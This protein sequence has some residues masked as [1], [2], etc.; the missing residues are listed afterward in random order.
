ME[1]G[2]LDEYADWLDTADHRNHAS[3]D[4]RRENLFICPGTATDA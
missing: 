3:L 4:N 2:W 1:A